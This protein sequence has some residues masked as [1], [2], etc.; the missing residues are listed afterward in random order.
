M[1]LLLA[2]LG[3]IGLFL[4]GA[5]FLVGDFGPVGPFKGRA[6][7]WGQMLGGIQFYAITAELPT[8]IPALFVVLASATF[9]LLADGLRA[10]SDP[11]SSRRVLPG[12]FG[13]LTKVLVGALCF[14]AV[15]FIGVNVRPGAMTMEEGRSL[16]AKTDCT[17][18]GS[19]L[20]R[21]SSRGENTQFPYP[22]FPWMRRRPARCS[23]PLSGTRPRWPPVLRR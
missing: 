18:A 5:T 16:A 11:F 17:A 9:A 23:Q 2:E 1:L 13:V 19:S 3:L 21:R 4:A 10:A 14:S 8:L 22:P 7:E 12:T 15:G 6:P 20:P